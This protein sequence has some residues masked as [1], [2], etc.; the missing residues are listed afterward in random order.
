MMFGTWGGNSNQPMTINFA[1]VTKIDSTDI[2]ND[3]EFS[4]KVKLEIGKNMDKYGWITKLSS[5]SRGHTK[6]KVKIE[7]IDLTEDQIN[8]LNRIKNSTKMITHKGRYREMV[9]II[10]GFCILCA[11]IPT[12]KVTH[13]M[14]G[15]SLIERY[16]DKCFEKVR[17]NETI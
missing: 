11:G 3:R 12:K 4:K 13:D 14:D 6:P 16:C 15:A 5:H 2:I 10:G 17:I 8:K 1:N 9:K 7:S